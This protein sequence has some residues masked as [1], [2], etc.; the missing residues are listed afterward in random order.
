[1]ESIQS[2]F[3]HLHWANVRINN[4]LLSLSEPNKQAEKLFA[5][6]LLAERVWITRL[7]GK[8]S[9]H[10]PIWTDLSLKS[11]DELLHKNHHDYRTYLSRVT[12]QGIEQ[13]VIYKNS[14]GEEFHNSIRNILVHVALHGQ[15]HRGQINLLLRQN[16]E[17]PVSTD[18]II[19]KREQQ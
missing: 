18:Y 7:V 13:I 16:D 14:T 5:H 15:Y 4:T 6:T 11:C 12:E 19:F 10:L 8:S 17:E 2:M 9:A 3:D 1:M